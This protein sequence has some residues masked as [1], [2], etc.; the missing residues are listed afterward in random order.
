MV[1]EPRKILRARSLMFPVNISSENG[2]ILT[3]FDGFDAVFPSTGRTFAQADVAIEMGS[4][5]D[6]KTFLGTRMH[7]LSSA[8]G[9][10]TQKNF[11]RAQFN[12]SSEY[13]E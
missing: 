5:S 9:L 3:T 12:V 2:A 10:R 4:R 1:S 11:A 13:F 6:S 8:D 7:W